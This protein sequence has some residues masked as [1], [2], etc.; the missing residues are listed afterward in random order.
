MTHTR[1]WIMAQVRSTNTEP[2]RRVRSWLWRHGF[3]FRRHVKG[4][5]GT[6]DIVLPKYK[7][8]IDVRGCFWHRHPD[9][10]IATMPKSRG[11]FWWKKFNANVARDI[12]N[13]RRLKALGWNVIVLWECDISD[14]SLRAIEKTLT[15][16]SPRKLRY[17]TLAPDPIFHSAA[18]E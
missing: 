14:D 9:C 5:P 8:V 17:D 1:S 16:I 6:P 4:L 10:K 3:R 7:T 12:E 11:K 18:E 2:E 13:E 15:A